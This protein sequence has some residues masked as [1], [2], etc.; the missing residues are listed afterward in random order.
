[1]ICEEAE[2]QLAKEGPDGVSDLDPE[3]LI[4]RIGTPSVVDVADHGGCDG[5]GENVV[6]IGKEADTWRSLNYEGTLTT[7]HS[8]ATTQAFA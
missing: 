1:M 5:N 8:P 6:C 2:K 3:I 4:G 7:V